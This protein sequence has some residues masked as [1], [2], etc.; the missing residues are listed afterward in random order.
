M[1][2]LGQEFWACACLNKLLVASR[3]IHT[4]FSIIYPSKTCLPKCH[5]DDISRSLIPVWIL[6][7]YA[8]YTSEIEG[9]LNQKW[10]KYYLTISV[11]FSTT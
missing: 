8:I 6:H 3:K 4:K 7:E 2:S 9:F 1:M 5:V 11:S 10:E